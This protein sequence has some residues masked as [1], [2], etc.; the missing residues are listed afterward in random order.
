MSVRGI[1]V[2]F[3]TNKLTLR[4]AEVSLFDY[5]DN[6][7]K[8]LGHYS[9]VMVRPYNLV[10]K[11]DPQDVNEA[12][13]DKFTQRFGPNLLY[14]ES[15]DEIPALVRKHDIA[16]LFIEKAGAPWDGL[17]FDCC[18]TIIHAIFTTEYPHGSIYCPISPFL[19]TR[20]KTSYPVLPNIVKIHPTEENLRQELGIAPAALVFASYG[21]QLEFDTFYVR[22]TI[23]EFIKTQQ[24][25]QHD[26]HF[27]F[28][29]HVV[30]GPRHP[31]LHFLSGTADMER[32]RQFINS[33]DAMI[34]G[35]KEG[36]TFGLAVA[37]FALA[38]KPVLA[39][40]HANARFH[41]DTLGDRAILHSNAEELLT[42][43]AEWPRALET[44]PLAKDTAHPYAVYSSDLVML[45]F[46]KILHS[47]LFPSDSMTTSITT[48]SIT[49]CI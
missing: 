18:P 12:A 37:E 2:G 17:V 39:S 13:Y 30:F 33:A 49:P 34:Y 24:A 25:V 11:A 44:N 20:F 32:K 48:P 6:N 38:G 10:A 43:L 31:R 15:P 45:K 46:N 21:G 5:A 29:N 22:R 28:M 4:G 16:V 8:I 40:R 41:L 19:N 23:C 26:C 36:E 3:V 27:I 35:R 42:I 14:Y 9:F 7:E 47:L 1:R